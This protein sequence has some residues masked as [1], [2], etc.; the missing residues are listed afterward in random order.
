MAGDILVTSSYGC[1]LLQSL[2][3]NAQLSCV[4][5]A[6]LK[7][8]GKIFHLYEILFLSIFIGTKTGYGNLVY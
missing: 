4:K 1:L 5:H 2:N 8:I 7:S 3:S 6:H